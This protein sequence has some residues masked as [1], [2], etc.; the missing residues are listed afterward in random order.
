MPMLQQCATFVHVEVGLGGCAPAGLV[1]RLAEAGSAYIKSGARNKAFE[2]LWGSCLPGVFDVCASLAGPRLGDIAPRWLHSCV[3]APEL[4]P[5]HGCFLALPGKHALMNGG[6]YT[7]ALW[8]MTMR[9]HDCHVLRQ[10]VGLLSSRRMLP[11]CTCAAHHW[12]VA[13]R[14]LASLHATCK[15]AI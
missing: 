7:L 8:C 10:G 9:N 3:F 4:G 12:A 2:P 14:A 15:Y 11:A 5:C 13:W 6:P 1:A